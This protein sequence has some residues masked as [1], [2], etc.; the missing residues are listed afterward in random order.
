MTVT[1]IATTAMGLEAVLGRE[2]K[3]LGYTDVQL[4]DGKAEFKGTLADICKA[5]WQ[6]WAC[7]ELS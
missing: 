1:I 3:D 6:R 5:N 2:L 4:S 7:I